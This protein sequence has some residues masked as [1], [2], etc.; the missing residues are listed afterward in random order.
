M[1]K[2]KAY[3]LHPEGI[4]FVNARKASKISN[5]VGWHAAAVLRVGHMSVDG[6]RLSHDTIL[7]TW[8]L[9]FPP[10]SASVSRALSQAEGQNPHH[11]WH[12]GHQT[13]Q[14]EPAK[15]QWCMQPFSTTVSILGFWWIFFILCCLHAIFGSVIIAVV[16]QR[17]VLQQQR[18]LYLFAH[19]TPTDALLPRQWYHQRCETHSFHTDLY[20]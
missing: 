19:H 16:V 6:F 11:L 12:P 10:A 3:S 1:M 9:I 5:D 7:I 2:A 4:N 8:F 15:P 13:S 18:P 14:D 20:N 17:E